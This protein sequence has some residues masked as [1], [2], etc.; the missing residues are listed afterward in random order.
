MGRVHVPLRLVAPDHFFL[1]VGLCMM[2]CMASKAEFHACLFMNAAFL[3]GNVCLPYWE[4]KPN[5]GI[6]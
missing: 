3:F 4:V 5:P 1:L 2:L 6:H